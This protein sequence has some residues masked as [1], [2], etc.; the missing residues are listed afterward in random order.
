[1]NNIL[2]KTIIA[3]AISA[4]AVSGA[5]AD[6]GMW[7]PSLVGSRIADMQAKGFKLSASDIYDVNQAS[8]KDAVVLFGRGCT[9]ELISS[10]G[11]V[12]TNHHCGYS[13]IQRHSTV[14]HDYLKDGFWAMT[15]KDE[16][17]CKGLTVS[18]LDR[19]E[20][21]TSVILQG[22]E[23]TMDEN[24]RVGIVRKNSKALTDKIAEE[25]LRGTVEALYYGNQYFLFVYREYRDVRFVGAPPSSIGKFGGD[26]DN[27]MW[28]R[29]T[30][31]FSMFRVYTDKDG[32]PAD[33][34]EDNVPLHPRKY[35]KI[36]TQGVHENDF[37]FI[38]GFPG[39]TQE[40][41]H[42]EGVRYIAE[43]GDPHKIALRTLRLDIQKKYMKQSQDLRIR[44]SAKNAT[45]SNAWKKWQGESGGIRKMNTVAVKQQF[46]KDFAVWAKGS[47]YEGLTERIAQIYKNLEPYA[48]AT[49]Y[50]NEAIRTI[51]IANFAASISKLYKDGKFS[52]GRF[53]GATAS[54][55]KDYYLPID[56]ESFIAVIQKYADNVPQD[57]QPEYF[58]AQMS[59]YGNAESW[60]EDLFGKTLFADS[61][62]VKAL[63]DSSAAL[64][65]ADPATLFAEK[66]ADWFAENIRP[67]TKRLNQEL[68]LAYRDYMRGQMEFAAGAKDFYP[69]ANLTLRVAY[70]H[71]SGYEPMDGVYY[72][73]SSTLEG[74]MEKDNPEIFDYN[75]PQRLRDI[76]AA[77][78]FGKWTDAEGRVPVCFIA[79]NHTT[80][81]NSGSPVINADGNLIG[82]NFDRVWEGTM[83]D[84]VFDPDVCRNIA[85][86]IRYVLF[87][88]DRLAGAQRLL[89]ELTLVD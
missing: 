85:L 1:M 41:I 57:F 12:L 40:Y 56:K 89:K 83:S 10:E 43:V 39:S 15:Q 55:Y 70:G 37:T 19:M 67:V 6:E 52:K 9:G 80:G 20:D 11:L 30:G 64:V 79:T 32:K 71:V 45:I 82:I 35:F 5:K 63:T 75:I 59:V 28:P 84:I 86:D 88:L 73:P 69:D 51:E 23:P 46:E 16:L 38:Y 26:T 53:E 27:W 31:D 87:T 66:C 13:M 33:Y 47:A 62:K 72:K 21:V 29:H 44:Y 34:S 50:Y 4:L 54:F 14:E 3:L 42:S 77:K 7:L 8:L 24:E 49:D 61:E 78:D 17:P 25:G 65:A 22:Y 60:A 36:S 74:V 18:F 76:Y 2:K 68:Q 81:G 58:K 48:F